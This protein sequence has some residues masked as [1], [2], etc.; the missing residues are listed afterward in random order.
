MPLGDGRFSFSG[1]RLEV[2]S[3]QIAGSRSREWGEKVRSNRLFNTDT[4]R[5]AFASLPASSHGTG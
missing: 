4:V 5:R 2:P 1:M 3:L